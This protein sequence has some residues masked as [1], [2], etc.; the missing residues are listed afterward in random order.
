MSL[1]S[2]MTDFFN[3][4]DTLAQVYLDSG[5]VESTS[6]RVKRMELNINQE[7][8]SNK[9]KLES[10]I[11]FNVESG[12]EPDYSKYKKTVSEYLNK[13]KELQTT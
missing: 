6:L 5:R 4:D 8:L 9:L 10:R 1:V 11:I 12:V 13:I 7:E 3:S 2:Q